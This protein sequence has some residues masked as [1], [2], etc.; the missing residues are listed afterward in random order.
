MD[1]LGADLLAGEHPNLF[2]RPVCQ[3]LQSKD[4][5]DILPN[6]FGASARQ[7]QSERQEHNEKRSSA[8]PTSPVDKPRLAARLEGFGSYAMISTLVCTMGNMLPNTS[9]PSSLPN[10]WPAVRYIFCS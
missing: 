1:S 6:L 7:I 9:T 2:K 4:S 8:T 10:M 3:H 5:S